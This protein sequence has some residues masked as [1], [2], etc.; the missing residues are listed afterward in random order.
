M[1]TGKSPNGTK[2]TCPVPSSRVVVP[3][4]VVIAVGVAGSGVISVADATAVGGSADSEAAADG[5]IVTV[6]VDDGVTTAAGTV[7]SVPDPGTASRC[8]HAASI[9]DIR[10]D[11]MI[12]TRS[13]SVSHPVSQFVL[14]KHRDG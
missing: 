2:Y 12:A 13:I 10:I 8:L 4:V 14:L 6:A 3:V 11:S 1:S 9:K 7:G 5:A